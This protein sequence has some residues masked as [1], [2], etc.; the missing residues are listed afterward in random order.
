MFSR[1]NYIFKVFIAFSLLSFAFTLE[2]RF[3]YC[4]FNHGSTKTLLC[5]T[6]TDPEL[7]KDYE[8]FSRL[9]KKVYTVCNCLCISTLAVKYFKLY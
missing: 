4:E 8:G 5:E 2:K 9:I 1:Y 3:S 6:F 7:K